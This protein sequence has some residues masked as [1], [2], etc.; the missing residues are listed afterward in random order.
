MNR[1]CKEGLILNVY[2][3]IPTEHTLQ[4]N[5]MCTTCEIHRIP[6]WRVLF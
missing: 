3:I 5:G 6:L 2:Y 1:N 4:P